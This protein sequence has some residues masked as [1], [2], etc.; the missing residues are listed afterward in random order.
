MTFGSLFSGIGG[1]DLGLTR[2]GLTCSWQVEVDPFARRVLARHWPEA[3]RHDDIKTFP[4]TGPEDWPVDLICGG[5][6]CQGNSNAGSVH[7]RI[8][9]D[10][11]VHFLRVVEAIR[12]RLVLRENPTT[13]RPDAPWPWWRF[14]SGLESLGYAVLP[15]RLRACCAGLDH[16]RDRMF[17]LGEVSHPDSIGLERLDRQWFATRDTGRVAGYPV[18]SRRHDALPAPRILRAGDGFPDRVDRTRGLG[19]AV[20]PTAAELIG[21]L[22]LA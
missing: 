12:P 11:A 13:L 15:F 18:A 1:F 16:R 21:R 5:D 20:V 10:L 6:P 22:L 4:P 14:R 9:E 3:R 7:R 19:N 8:H 2:A 17:L